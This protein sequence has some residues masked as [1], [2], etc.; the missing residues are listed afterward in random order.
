M[1]NKIKLSNHDRDK[2]LADLQNPS[3]P[4]PKLRALARK[5][6]KMIENGKLITDTKI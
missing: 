6:K 1:T 5:Y 3:L 2:F 4:C